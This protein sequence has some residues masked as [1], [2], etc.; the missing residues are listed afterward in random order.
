M[1]NIIDE[2]HVYECLDKKYIFYTEYQELP[3]NPDFIWMFS[4]SWNL[5]GFTEEMIQNLNK[6]KKEIIYKCL[7]TIEDTFCKILEI[8]ISLNKKL[9]KSYVEKT[10]KERKESKSTYNDKMAFNLNCHYSIINKERKKIVDE[11]ITDKFK[12]L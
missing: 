9:E 2:R 6:D 1:F 3:Y 11:F 8:K 7:K 4:W 12:G 5:F 10:L